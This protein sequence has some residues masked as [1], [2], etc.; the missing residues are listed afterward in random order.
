MIRLVVPAALLA[1]AAAAPAPAQTDAPA[2][3]TAVTVYPGGAE[4]TRRIAVEAA[5]G[6]QAIRIPN[7]TIGL[8]PASLRAATDAEHLEIASVDVEHAFSAEANQ[9]EARALEARIDRLEAERAALEDAVRAAE[10]Q[11]ALVEA[12][13]RGAADGEGEGE[14]GPPPVE[15]W[16]DMLGFIG[17]ASAAAYARQREARREIEAIEAE[18]EKAQGELALLRDGS[19]QSYTAVI[20]LASAEAEPGDLTLTYRVGD[21]GWRPLYD[22]RIDTSAETLELTQ[23]AEVIQRTGEPWDGVSLS[24]ATSQ[25]HLGG[26]LP[27]LETWFVDLQPEAVAKELRR[28]GA[29]AS[30]DGFADEAEQMAPAPAPEPPVALVAGDFSATYVVPGR[31]HVPADGTA[32]KV[33]L[34][35]LDLG[36]SLHASVVPALSP[37]AHLVGRLTWEGEAPLLPG[38]VSLYRDGAFV[39]RHGLAM[40]RPG[41]ERELSLG[42]DER[43]AV[44]RRLAGGERGSSGLIRTEESESRLYRTEITNHHDRPLGIAVLDRMPV[45]RHEDIEVEL[46]S[47]STAPTERDV[48]DRE[49]VLAWRHDYAPG[50]TRVIEFGY[51]VRFPE[52]A[53]LTN[54]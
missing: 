3:I 13:V 45:P 17:E 37:V 27:E 30:S 32:K 1:A 29:P 25:P 26:P 14:S 20:A 48:D 9:A 2:P 36:L 51:R 39:G 21:A 28:G 19:R 23:L 40:L 7:L 8:D 24:L 10:R 4:V 15:H 22:A 53:L 12:L 33:R 16:Q 18:L 42:A 6:E 44:E 47:E 5:T 41:E 11:L 34:D 54:F 43:I 46:M 50:E 35:R 49:G 31:V 52:E 38:Q